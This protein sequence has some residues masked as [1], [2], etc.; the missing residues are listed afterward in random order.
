MTACCSIA[1][2][3]EILVIIN[4]VNVADDTIAPDT[5]RSTARAFERAARKARTEASYNKTDR[6]RFGINRGTG[7][8]KV[9]KRLAARAS[10]RHAHAICREGI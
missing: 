6:S 4:G 7:A 10:R 3:G 5:T 9:A 2:T 8:A 1:P